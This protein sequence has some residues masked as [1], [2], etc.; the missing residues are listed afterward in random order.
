VL[1][2]RGETDVGHDGD[3]GLDHGLD[4]GGIVGAALDLDSVGQAF[5]EEPD[6]GADCLLRGHLIAAERQVGHDERPLGAAG[7]GTA[8][9][10]QLVHRD[11]KAGLVAEDVVRG[12][13]T[14]EEDLNSGFIENFGCVLLV[15]SQHGE[16]RPVPLGL[17][18]VV[19]AHLGRL[20]LRRSSRRSCLARPAA[21]GGGDVGGHAGIGAVA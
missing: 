2:L 8:Q 11:R 9:G 3:A 14:D 20:P 13:I 5:L 4:R 18:Q 12:R 17:L 21:V 15:G 19:D 6:A 10:Q 16:L 7:H 1:A